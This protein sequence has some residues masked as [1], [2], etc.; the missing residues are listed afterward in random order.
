LTGMSSVVFVMTS[1]SMVMGDRP[2]RRL[3]DI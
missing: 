3:Y 2:A 1:L